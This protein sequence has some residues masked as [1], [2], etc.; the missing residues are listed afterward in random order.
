MCFFLEKPKKKKT[1]RKKGNPVQKIDGFAMK[2]YLRTLKNEYPELSRAAIY[3]LGGSGDKTYITLETEDE[4]RKFNM[5]YDFED[6]ESLKEKFE[7]SVRGQMALL[8]DLYLQNSKVSEE[9]IKKKANAKLLLDNPRDTFELNDGNV[10][11]VKLWCE[12]YIAKHG[13]MNRQAWIGLDSMDT[14]E[15]F[16]GFFAERRE[17]LQSGEAKIRTRL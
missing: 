8:S 14:W 6:M 15:S 11:K 16:E 12:W 13:G 4:G 5:L 1:K 2:A 7:W 10:E 9:D 17:H 3:K